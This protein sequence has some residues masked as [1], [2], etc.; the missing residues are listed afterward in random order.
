[1]KWAQ[2][3]EDKTLHDLPYKI[4]LNEWGNIEMSPASNR[5]G[6][7]QAAIMFELNALMTSGRFFCECS[8]RTTKNVK[9]ADVV[10]GS[11]EFFRQNGERTPFEVAPEI[12][13]EV[14]SPS[15]T[16]E[17][18]MMKRDVYV[19]QGCREFWSSSLDSKTAYSYAW[20]LRVD[21][22]NGFSNFS[23]RSNGYHV[24]L[25]RSQ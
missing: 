12:C 7:L 13:V 22:L 14:I 11:D 1:M 17:E 10:W 9:V 23:V 21:F 4:E 19:E 24:R 2:V 20:A 25:V 6:M 15:N 3:L 18:M 5:H 16:K 8:I